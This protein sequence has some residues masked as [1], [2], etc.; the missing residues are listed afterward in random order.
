MFIAKIDKLNN[1]DSNYEDW[2]FIPLNNYGLRQQVNSVNQDVLYACV[3]AYSLVT[4]QD[5]TVN[6]DEI[7][8]IR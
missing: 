3:Y 8:R 5:L 6:D 2:N 7:S 4:M 1:K